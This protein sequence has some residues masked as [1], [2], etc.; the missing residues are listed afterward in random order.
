MTYTPIINGDPASV[1]L[2]L[3]PGS[4]AL[5]RQYGTD[6]QTMVFSATMAEPEVVPQSFVQGTQ[7]TLTYNG[8]PGKVTIEAIHESPLAVLD[9]VLGQELVISWRAS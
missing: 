6:A 5:V 4:H 1:E 2:H 9:N 8:Q 7:G 3:E